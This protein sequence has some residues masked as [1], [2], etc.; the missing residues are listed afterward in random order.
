MLQHRRYESFFYVMNGII[1]TDLNGSAFDN[2][3]NCYYLDTCCTNDS[4]TPEE[5]DIEIKTVDQ[6]K[7][8]EIA[9]LLQGEQEEAVWGQTLGKDIYP[10]FGG[11][12]VYEVKNCDDT[13]IYRNE[14]ISISEHEFENGFCKGCKTGYQPAIDLNSDGYYEITNGGQLYRFAQL[15]N[16]GTNT[17][18]SAILMNDIVVNENLLENLNAKNIREWTPINGDHNGVFDG[19]GFTISGLYVNSDNLKDVG[20]Y[21]E[22]RAT[23]KNVGIV[24]SYYYVTTQSASIGGVVGRNYGTVE[25][26]YFDGE[27]E[28]SGADSYAGGVVGYNSGECITE[29]CYNLGNITNSYTGVGVTTTGGIVG[30]NFGGT[31]KNSYNIGIVTNA[32]GTNTV[33][34]GSILGCNFGYN[35]ESMGMGVGYA[36]VE[37]CY[38][39]YSDINAIGYK[40]TIN[41]TIDNIVTVSEDD[42]ASGEIAYS[43][44]GDSSDGIWGQKI[45]KDNKPVLYGDK[46]Y[47]IENCKE[48]FIKYS[49]TY[50]IIGHVEVTIK[51]KNATCTETGLTDGT[52]CSVC[53]EIL[54]EQTEIPAKGHT[55]VTIKGKDATCTETGLTDGTKCSVCNKTL[56]AQ[57]E[58][59]AEGHKK[60]TIKGKDA[61]C[62]ETGLTD[63]TK[64]SV[65]SKTLVEQKEIPAEGHKKVTIEGK[66][67]TC[68]ET[69]LTVGTKCSV[70]NI[71]LVAQEIIP[72]IG[73]HNYVNDYCTV[74]GIKEE[75]RIYFIPSTN[76]KDANARF[77]A[78]FFGG[79]SGEAWVS[80]TATSDGMY[81]GVM[82]KGYTNVIFVRMNPA[83][84]ENNWNNGTK[85]NQTADLTIYGNC[86]TLTSTAW[87]NGT[88]TW[89][90][91]DNPT[92]PTE[93]TT[94]PTT[95]PTAENNIYFV[96]STN[97]KEANAR[98]SA[99]FFNG[100]SEPQWVSL[101]A[102]SKGQYVGT[103]PTGYK[104]VIFVRMNPDTTN[105]NWDNGTK[106][107]QTADLTINGNCF[108]LNSGEWDGANGT[109]STIVEP[110]VPPTNPPTDKP[111]VPPTNPPTDEPTVP[112]TTPPTE[113]PTEAPTQ[114]PTKPASYSVTGDIELKL[115]PCGTNKVRGT[116]VLQPGTYKFK[117]N[118]YGTLLGYGKTFTDSTKG[119]TFKSTFSSF[120][121]INATGGTYTFQVSTD[122]NALVVNY[123][124]NLPEEYLVG[125]INT[126]L[127]PV[128]GKPLAIGATYL[129]AGTYQFKISDNTVILGNGSS[130]TDGT[131]GRSVSF[132]DTYSKYYTL[133]ATGGTYTFTYYTSTQKLIIGCVQNVDEA[134]DDVHISGDIK[135]VLNDNNGESNIATGKVTLTEGK[136][137]F[138]VY[139]YGVA[140]CSGSTINNTGK[141]TLKSTYTKNVTLF[142]NGGTYE[143]T[144]N[145]TTGELVVE[146]V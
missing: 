21:G 12:K 25:G 76:W 126:I 88:G 10:I 54:V 56:V 62:T 75:K 117:L 127:T 4:A 41:S 58:I 49:N 124:S 2:V 36:Y 142:A 40:S 136:Y 114:A 132:K 101:T 141:K 20:L 96:P 66:S 63:G 13:D 90:T 134:N 59:P 72:A 138:K 53:D 82:P 17:N 74:C 83:T 125:D 39:L 110:T 30:H 70:C 51:G 33:R 26:C 98:F 1:G 139:N 77:A 29:N 19:N 95:N 18:A 38:A 87:D 97:W 35:Y 81:T 133:N 46:V 112:P 52:K 123:D 65:C 103:M 145:K 120:C 23:V 129:E 34:V 50:E 37:N 116:I 47:K 15:I 93:P 131:A 115:T 5:C 7:S 109:W 99:Y 102:N 92:V 8:G 9:Y 57:K 140:Y 100:S 104:S 84:T 137:S 79:N 24:D 128:A 78:Y 6:F 71:T 27:I 31:V 144:F 106:W 43:L 3:T 118:N 107:N 121:T 111:T 67:A 73:K 42:F 69:G 22:N 28:F 60:V 146:S 64:C 61:T 113:A 105:N 130:C 80:L 44:N 119:L 68:T 108:T 55:K 85:W 135:L 89:K 143:F 45:G 32:G 14:N 91:I 122:K 16:S 48:E 11:A 86:F 94:Q